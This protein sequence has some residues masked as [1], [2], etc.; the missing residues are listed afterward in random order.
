MSNTISAMR[1]W[2]WWVA[3]DQKHDGS[4]ATLTAFVSIFAVFWFLRAIMKSTKVVPPLPPGPRGLPL[5][6]YL[7]FLGTELHRKFEELA[8]SYGPIYK[9]WLGQKLCVVVSSPSLVKEVVRDQDRVFANRDPPIAG[10]AASYGGGDIAFAPYGD[11]WKKLRKIFVRE[12]LSGANLDGSQTLLREE[13]RKSIRNVYEK[14]GSPIDLGELA[15]FTVINSTI[16]MLWGGTLRGEEGT[17]VGAQ[18]KSV[19]A[20][21]MVLFG[22]PNVSDF[23]PVLARFDL[24]GIERQA[25]RNFQWIE[26]IL[27]S[28]IEKR[29]NMAKEEKEGVE[30]MKDFLQILLEIRDHQVDAAKSI[31]MN[32]L[33]AL[34]LVCPIFYFVLHQMRSPTQL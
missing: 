34:L 14:S 22:K 23:F 8:I 20:E 26:S 9:L 4:R 25:K 19:L 27:D 30:E 21:Q 18:F 17:A 29:M 15:F 11:D 31:S 1:S 28:V 5:V 13:V 12:M 33:K 6:G 3:E 2:W 16:N 7:P 32:Q 24:Q 10:L